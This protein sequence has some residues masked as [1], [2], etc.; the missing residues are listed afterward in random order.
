VGGSGPCTCI[1][2]A[3]AGITSFTA[4]YDRLLELCAVSNTSTGSVLDD[5]DRITLV[6]YEIEPENRSG[7]LV[8]VKVTV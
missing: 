7:V 5:D 8:G 6:C 4:Q 1:D 2:D 3:R